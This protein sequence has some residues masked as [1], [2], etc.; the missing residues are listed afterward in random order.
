MNSI[1][2]STP[3]E[4]SSVRPIS[5]DPYRFRT[6]RWVLITEAVLLIAL[7]AGG[8]LANATNTTPPPQGAPVLV[9]HFTTLHSA[10]L[11]ATGLLASLS[12][13]RRTTAL[14]STCAQFF[15]YLLMFT[16]GSVGYARAVPT[17]LGLDPGDAM[18]HLALTALA[19]G[20][21]M[22]LAGHGIEGRWWI[23]DR[24]ST[25]PQPGNTETAP[26]SRQDNFAASPGVPAD[27][28]TVRT[29]RDGIR[30]SPPR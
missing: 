4:D 10:I 29:T 14:I 19:A 21:F 3:G 1:Q 30:Q 6:G 9:F 8:L 2:R 11:L 17:P 5:P 26:H 16:A 28:G 13:A 7:G 24:S 15:G 12:A 20:L 27:T 25:R 22:W 18:L 23:Y